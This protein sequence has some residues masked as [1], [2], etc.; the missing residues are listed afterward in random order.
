MNA[1]NALSDPI[2][3]VEH[4]DS[5][6][7]TSR[8]YVMDDYSKRLRNGRDASNVVY[9]KELSRLVQNQF[10]LKI[11]PADLL[12]CQ[13]PQNDTVQDCPV[14]TPENKV[15]KDFLVVV[16]NS[17]PRTK[18][19][20]LKVLLPCPTYKPQI[21]NKESKSFEDTVFD[22]IELT[23]FT[24][25]GTNVTDFALYVEATI[26][27]DEVIVIKIIRTPS[28]A[29]LAQSLIKDKKASDFGLI[30]QGVSDIGDVIF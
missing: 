21:W 2:S 20:L 25:N 26:P 29:N 22:I 14:A 1:T 23:H 10:G 18:T 16:H 27:T 9:K 24:N 28:K 6:T 11:K 7:G 8:Q 4:H 13:G 3:I 15:K 12:T 19:E 30:V 5:V 17:Q